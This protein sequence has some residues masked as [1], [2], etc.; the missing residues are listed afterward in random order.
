MA[1]KS[2][3]ASHA[4]EKEA[5]K[6]HYA[7][8]KEAAKIHYASH[9]LEKEAAKVY[10]SSYVAERQEYFV[11]YYASHC[12]EIKESHR[13]HYAAIANVK[14]AKLHQKYCINSKQ[15]NAL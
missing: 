10:C 13:D 15:I 7:E 14:N 2:H 4:E 8:E 6:N 9:A 3:Y 12:Q 5:A 1:A 11:K